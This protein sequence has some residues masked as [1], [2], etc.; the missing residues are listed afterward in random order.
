MKVLSIGNEGDLDL[1]LVGQSL[2]R[3]GAAITTVE[4]E[5]PSTWPELAGFD[6]VVSLG[7]EWSVYWPQ[8]SYSVDPECAL[9]AAAH[10]RCTPVFG[11]CF[12]SQ[13][14]A[15]ALGGR[16]ERAPIA[17]IGWFHVTPTAGA[18]TMIE[19]GPWFQ[20]H[21]DRWSPP[22]AA[23]VLAISPASNQVFKLDRSIAVQYHPEV[24]IDVVA[25][26][27]SGNGLPELQ[28]LGIDFDE[29][30][31]HTEAE[32]PKAAERTDRFIL[33]LLGSVIAR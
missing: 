6:L 2:A 29:L 21:Y 7:S 20:W 23:D 3:L 12:G 18:E 19:P 30:M 5:H 16:V 4:R 31:A 10:E 26:W 17:E 8:V 15:R 32:V 27:G 11:I 24:T 1:G 9:L 22:P 33:Q 25:R 14:L 13:L 28:R